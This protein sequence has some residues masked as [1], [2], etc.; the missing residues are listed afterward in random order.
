MP[1]L[2]KHA[3]RGR[4]R[5]MRGFVIWFCVL[6]AIGSG[7]GSSSCTG[8]IVQ[9]L[10]KEIDVHKNAILIKR[11]S[12]P[13]TRLISARPTSISLLQGN[14]ADC[15]ENVEF[16]T[17]LVLQ[18]LELRRN[19]VTVIRF[20]SL[21]RR[22]LDL[23]TG[24]KPAG[25]VNVGISALPLFDPDREMIALMQTRNGSICSAH[26]CV[27]NWGGP[28]YNQ[29]FQTEWYVERERY[30]DA[31]DRVD[32]Y[33]VVNGQP[34]GKIFQLQIPKHKVFTLES[35]RAALAFEKDA[36]DLVVATVI[37]R[38]VPI[39]YDRDYDGSGL[40]VRNLAQKDPEG[41][42]ELSNRNSDPFIWGEDVSVQISGG[43]VDERPYKIVCSLQSSLVK[44]QVQLNSDGSLEVTREFAQTTSLGTWFRSWLTNWGSE[45]DRMKQIPVD[46][47]LQILNNWRAWEINNKELEILWESSG[48][49]R[50][51]K[52]K[53]KSLGNPPLSYPNPFTDEFV[54]IQKFRM[55]RPQHKLSTK[56][57]D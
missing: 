31:E 36:R 51:I 57:G 39:P 33:S 53:P 22:D 16:G 37:Y 19:H 55:A 27:T 15:G 45:T 9:P 14:L 47:L 5:D 28:S 24:R 35:A 40:S 8:E 43:T 10:N 23:K 13:P 38:P 20:E 3:W 49:F 56:I 18:P 2:V 32:I 1:T 21:S 44:G 25:G 34:I 54:N 29:F 26:Y 6:V 50:L 11:L 52:L 7:L 4:S 12:S 46:Y 42:W 48:L 30:S 17:A 41:V